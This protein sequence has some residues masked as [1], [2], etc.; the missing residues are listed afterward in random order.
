MAGEGESHFV[1]GLPQ[2]LEWYQ[3]FFYDDSQSSISKFS[4][5]TKQLHMEDGTALQTGH[6]PRPL[7]SVSLGLLS[8]LLCLTSGGGPPP[9][10]S[11]RVNI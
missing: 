8:G 2:P 10:R 3:Q 5:P 7:G 4:M 9:S 11:P 1:P 6:V